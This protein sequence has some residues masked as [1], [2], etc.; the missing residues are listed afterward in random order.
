[1]AGE[2]GKRRQTNKEMLDSATQSIEAKMNDKSRQ[3]RPDQLGLD[4]ANRHKHDLTN[5]KHNLARG[6]V[7]PYRLL[8]A[9]RVSALI[10]ASAPASRRFAPSPT[11]RCHPVP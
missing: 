8:R 6:I 2:A 1:M 9:S 10:Y 11:M 3:A 5:F 7:P 4:L